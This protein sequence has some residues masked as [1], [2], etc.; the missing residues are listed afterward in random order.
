MTIDFNTNNIVIVFYPRFAGGKFLINCLGLSDDAVFQNAKL[1]ENQLNG[2]FTIDNKIQYL[3]NELDNVHDSWT[4]LNLF[5]CD[6]FGQDGISNI[7]SPEVVKQNSQLFLPVIKKLSNSNL[8]FFLVASDIMN[9]KQDILIWN[10]ARIILFKNSKNF[11]N[12]RQKNN[13][14]DLKLAGSDKL[15]FK[16]NQDSIDTKLKNQTIFWD[17]DLF[18]SCDATVNRIEQLYSELEL[19]NFNREYIVKYYNQWISKLKELKQN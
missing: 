16:E 15:P 1:A 17:N 3:I 19:T 14:N 8:K 12:F 5:C 18:F 6:L 11:I 10:N 4:D 2:K 9:L 7:N 13:I